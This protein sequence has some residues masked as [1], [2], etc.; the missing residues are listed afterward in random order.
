MVTVTV[1]AGTRRH[2]VGYEMCGSITSGQLLGR[3]VSI[4]LMERRVAALVIVQSKCVCGVQY[5]YLCDQF[6]HN[7]LEATRVL[8]RNV[9]GE[10]SYY[11][12]IR[13][14]GQHLLKNVGK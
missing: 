14:R 11:T 4:L 9:D 2:S 5:M 8:D 12:Y 3:C 13:L 6:V 1:D 7:Q 10:M